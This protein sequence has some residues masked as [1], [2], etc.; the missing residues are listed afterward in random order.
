GPS[1]G[2]SWSIILETLQQA[3][4]VLFS[5]AKAPGKIPTAIK[6]QD[7]QAENEANALMANFGGEIR[8]VE[9]A[10]SRLV[11]ST[12]DFPNKSFVEVVEA[13]CKLLDPGPP[14]ETPSGSEMPQSPPSPGT[15]LQTPAQHRRILSVS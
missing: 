13:I 5:C 8:A 10:A 3:D 7:T 11:E 1:L 4:F 14:P 2:K 9:I 15:T 12:V 6:G